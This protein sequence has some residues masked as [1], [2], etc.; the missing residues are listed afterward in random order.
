MKEKRKTAKAV[1]KPHNLM[2]GKRFGRWLVLSH[3]CSGYVRCRCDCG[4]AR[5]VGAR[6]LRA[7]KT[8]SCSC[9]QREITA[10]RSYRHGHAGKVKSREY[11][12]WLNM[13]QRTRNP[14]NK[15]WALYGGR[16]ISISKRFEKSF[17]EFFN[18]VGPKP[19]RRHSIDRIKNS[20][21]YAPGNLRWGTP[22]MQAANRRPPTRRK[23]EA[24]QMG[25][26]A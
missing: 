14:S 16:G 7:G 3:A 10:Q 25:G 20:K 12:T 26:A 2:V 19:S 18:H 22:K 15:D 6:N 8:R 21:G 11:Q 1:S 13:R 24:Q 5:L 9:L 17:L 4:T 23:I